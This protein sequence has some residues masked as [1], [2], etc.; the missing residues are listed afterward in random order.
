MCRPGP[1][2][3][4]WVDFYRGV[5]E[6]PQY[7]PDEIEAELDLRAGAD[8][9]RIYRIVR[10]A[11]PP[12][13]VPRLADLSTTEL[14]RALDSP[15]GTLRDLVQRV[16]V[17]RGDRQAVPALRKLAQWARR[18]IARVQALWTLE[19]LGQSDQETLL[20]ALTDRDG[21]VRAQ[22]VAI[23]ARHFGEIT[24][25][26]PAV[27]AMGADEHPRDETPNGHVDAQLELAYVM[28]ELPDDKAGKMLGK[29]IVHHAGDPDPFILAAALSSL[30]A[31]NVRAVVGEVLG[32]GDPNPYAV[33]QLLAFAAA[34]GAQQAIADGFTAA[35]TPKGG[36]FAPWQFA[37]LAGALDEA[38]HRGQ[39]LDGLIGPDAVAKLKAV[40]EAAR[41]DAVNDE[42]DD[43][44][45]TAAID[46]LGLSD[47]RQQDFEV[48]GALVEPQQSDV[49]QNAAIDAMARSGDERTGTTLL[50]H[51]ASFSPA[52]AARSLDVLLSHPAWTL[53]LLD[54]IAGGEIQANQLDAARRGQL[55]EHPTPEIRERAATLLEAGSGD[56]QKVIDTLAWVLDKPGDPV[57]G[58]KSF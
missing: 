8:R 2:G 27:I 7:I 38:R 9:G 13:K 18:P 43:V 49:I 31:N 23:A 11:A 42:L 16:L 12:R 32:A 41:A 58:G 6:H 48:L 51:W 45:R 40:G 57:H 21:A 54:K 33:G 56:R 4:L 20:A 1:D 28:G 25:L 15:S 55:L 14:V 17:W 52:L 44:Q 5:L 47:E 37:A 10:E 53:M 46:L 35:A 24:A 19:G 22:A 30:T 29:L 39:S 26:E 34:V 36:R 50:A 3:A